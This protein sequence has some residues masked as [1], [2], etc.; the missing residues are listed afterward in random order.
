MAGVTIA[1]R[2]PNSGFFLHILAIQPQTSTPQHNTISIVSA[3][4]I[5]SIHSYTP[6]TFSHLLNFLR[7]PL[8]FN[9][10]PRNPRSTSPPSYP[11][12]T[13]SS[14]AARTAAI[15]FHTPSDYLPATSPA[16][17]PAPL[18]SGSSSPRSSTSLSRPTSRHA[19]FAAE[20]ETVGLVVGRPRH[21]FDII[22]PEPGLRPPGIGEKILAFVISRGK[23][24]KGDM[25]G[26]TGRPLL[27]VHPF[28]LRLTRRYFTSVFVSL[29]VFLF[30]YDQGVMSG[31]ITYFR[32]G[33]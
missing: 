1:S 23:E 26:L 2:G 8:R 14:P 10:A 15:A 13:P 29:G 19:H 4:R 7:I 32:C 20:E 25:A 21:S 16:T 33:R 22:I 5:P 17:V 30:G 9:S 3:L 6:T 27:Y 12:F 18:K 11:Q 28:G 31:I 24:R